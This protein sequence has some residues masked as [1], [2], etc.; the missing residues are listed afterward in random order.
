MDN[1][2]EE[3]TKFSIVPIAEL[4]STTTES[5]QEHHLHIQT[6]EFGGIRRIEK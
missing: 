4:H 5:S 2:V 3:S 6:T 1:V